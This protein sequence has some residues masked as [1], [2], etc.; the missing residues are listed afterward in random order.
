[1]SHTQTVYHVVPNTSGTQWIIIMEN[2][3]A[4][5]QEHRTK[6]RAVEA[7]DE[8]AREQE[9]SRLKVHNS[10]GDIEYERAYGKPSRGLPR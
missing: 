8:L 2:S 9:P 5:R 3:G 10:D 4:F 6:D 1:M 7:A